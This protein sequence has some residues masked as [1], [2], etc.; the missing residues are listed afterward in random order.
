MLI[1]D[2]K[3]AAAAFTQLL[4]TPTYLNFQKNLSAGKEFFL[5]HILRF[6]IGHFSWKKNENQTNLFTDMWCGL[7]L[8]SV[9]SPISK[10]LN[11][12]QVICKLDLSKVL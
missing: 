1:A 12:I 6:K 7:I 5:E 8:K 4:D 3:E 9:V 2:N 10:N 11:E